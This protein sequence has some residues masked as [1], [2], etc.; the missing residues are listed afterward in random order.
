MYDTN[1]FVALVPFALLTL[2]VT[3]FLFFGHSVI[4]M[5][6]GQVDSGAFISELSQYPFE[7]VSRNE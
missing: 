3:F 7:K 6:V 5:K 1:K 4:E 2:K